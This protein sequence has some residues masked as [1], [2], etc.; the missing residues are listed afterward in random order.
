MG[1]GDDKSRTAKLHHNKVYNNQYKDVILVQVT[2]ADIST[3]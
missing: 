2:S 1:L 3:A